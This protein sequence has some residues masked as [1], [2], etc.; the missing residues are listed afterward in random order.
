MSDCDTGACKYYI[1]MSLG[2]KTQIVFK[3]KNHLKIM[4]FSH[5]GWRSPFY[6][7]SLHAE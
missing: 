1:Y 6:Q 3:G 4:H 2:E 5:G 7:D